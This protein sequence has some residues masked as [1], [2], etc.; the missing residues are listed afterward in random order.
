[1][2][3]LA[4]VLVIDVDDTDAEVAP[5]P[6][7]FERQAK[8]HGPA[9]RGRRDVTEYAVVGGTARCKLPL[10]PH[11]VG[12]HHAGTR[13]QQTDPAVLAIRLDERQ[14][15]LIG[16]V[17]TQV[18]GIAVDELRV[19]GLDRHVK[20]APTLTQHQAVAAVRTVPGRSEAQALVADVAV[21]V[22]DVTV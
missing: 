10:R 2:D 18:I 7:Q 4:G 19:G 20:L 5:R 3:D 17:E 11:V 16:P 13:K 1:V 15:H 12:R 21:P 8:L 22:A 9:V 6:E 14:T